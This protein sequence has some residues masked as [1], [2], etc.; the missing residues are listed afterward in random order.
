MERLE[1]EGHKNRMKKKYK[2]IAHYIAKVVTEEGKKEG[3]LDQ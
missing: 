2:C 3:N 1:D